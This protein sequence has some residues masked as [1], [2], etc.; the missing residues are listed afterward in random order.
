MDHADNGLC[1]QQRLEDVVNQLRDD[2]AGGLATLDGLIGKWP[3]DPR[4]HFL[5]GSV[6]AG[7]QR[8]EEGR[9]AMARALEIAPDFALARFQLGFLDFTSGHA[10]DAIGVW[11]PLGQ[12]SADE[13]LRLFAEGLSQLAVDNFP[14]ARR[15]LQQGMMHNRDNPLINADMQLIL[16][17]IEQLPIA[18]GG[19]DSGDTHGSPPEDAPASA[20][21]FL[22]QQSRLKGDTRH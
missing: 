6:L 8:Y 1:P 5:Q 20:V 7:L 13:P 3:L 21:Q 17:E 12:L 15:L 22:L 16:D 14:E 4:L 18:D 2:D 10:V 19:N 9:K 11:N